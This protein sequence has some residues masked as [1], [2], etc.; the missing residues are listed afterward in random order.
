MSELMES[1]FPPPKRKP[2]VEC[3]VCG[4]DVAGNLA[5]GGD[6]LV[7]NA[8]RHLPPGFGPSA[9]CRGSGEEG[10]PIK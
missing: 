4:R 10:I 8:V 6:G 5:K 9:P 2:R 1:L 7:L 3:K